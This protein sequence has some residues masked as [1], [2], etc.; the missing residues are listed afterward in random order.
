MKMSNKGIELLGKKK[1]PGFYSST[2]VT[3]YCSFFGIPV[4][5]RA[6]GIQPLLENHVDLLYP[7]TS[8][9]F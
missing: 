7:T 4:A 1:K 9:P 2:P 3:R 6:A 8:L 5:V